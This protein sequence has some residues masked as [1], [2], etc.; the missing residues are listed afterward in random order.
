MVEHEHKEHRNTVSAL[1]TRLGFVGLGA[2]GGGIARRLLDAGH[3]VT[4]TTGRR[5]KAAAAR[6]ARARA[7]GDAARGRR[8]R[9]RSCSR[10]SRHARRSRPSPTGPTG[11]S[12][13]S[14]PGSSTW[15]C[16][17]RRPENSRAL[18]A[19]V[20]ALGAPHAR[21]AGL[22]RGSRRSSRASLSVMVG[23]GRGR[24]RA[25]R[26]DPARHRPDGHLGRRER[27]GGA[28]EDR[29]ST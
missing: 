13:G 7:G 10:W 26:A 25:G 22:G 11:S 21:R 24:V 1:A 8:A 17:R 3:T 23:G 20:A 19:R 16:R 9:P 15:T 29:A 2:M 6:R 18:A 4:A 5:S 28:D 12:P 14:A 27:P